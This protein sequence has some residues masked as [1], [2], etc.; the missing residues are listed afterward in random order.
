MVSP[1]TLTSWCEIDLD[2]IAQNLAI[3]ISLLPKDTRFCAVLK[4]DA[5]GHGI[6]QVV[7]IITKQG[8]DCVGI[9]SNAE[10]AAVRKAG[11]SGQLM[12]LR[13]ATPCEIEHGT[14]YNVDEQ[15]N[16]VDTAL[17]LQALIK[18]GDYRSGIHLALN[19]NGMSR[20]GLELDTQSG[21]KTCKSIL[22][23]VGDRIVG[24][25]S[26]FPSNDPAQLRESA[27]L[28]QQ[29]VDW[30]ISNSQLERKD[31]LIHAG[32]S[33]TLVSD[34][35]IETD[36][37]RCGA[38]LYGILKPELG[39]ARQ[40]PFEQRSL[41]L[42]IFRVDQ[43]LA[44]IDQKPWIKI[45]SWPVFQLAIQMG[46]TDMRTKLHWSQFAVNCAKLSGKSR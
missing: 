43:P 3:A 21:R 15:V 10:A 25:C 17:Q 35:K 20:D 16:S 8:V 26:H 45:G 13:A 29:H 2:C 9:T 33:L 39:F 41:A 38:I 6:D 11:F 34:E 12:R 37:Y 32:S 4:A 5:Y 44:T 7:P 23:Q 18:N 19:A 27:E 24:V 28:F 1:Q 14:L 46:F 31:L 40:W 36:M 42:V 22:A 30:V